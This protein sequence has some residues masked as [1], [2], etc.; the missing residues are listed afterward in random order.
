M[1]FHH[2]LS[3]FYE[4][5]PNWRFDDQNFPTKVPISIKPRPETVFQIVWAVRDRTKDLSYLYQ[6]LRQSDYS[7]AFAQAEVFMPEMYFRMIVVHGNRQAIPS[8]IYQ[9]MIRT[10][11][12]AAIAVPQLTLLGAGL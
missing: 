4:G 3:S 2:G 10:D 11:L 5:Y 1:S 7:A 9:T 12:S 8:Y 6:I